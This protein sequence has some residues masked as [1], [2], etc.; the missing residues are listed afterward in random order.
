MDVAQTDHSPSAGGSYLKFFCDESY[1]DE[2]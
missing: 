2:A 1:L